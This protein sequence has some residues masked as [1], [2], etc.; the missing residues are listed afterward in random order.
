MHTQTVASGTPSAEFPPWLKP[1]VTPLPSTTNK[2]CQ[3]WVMSVCVLPRDSVR[4]Y[5]KLVFIQLAFVI[6]ADHCKEVWW[7][8]LIAIAD[9]APSI[10]FRRSHKARICLI[11]ALLYLRRVLYRMCLRGRM[12]YDETV[13][14]QLTCCF[15]INTKSTCN[16][17]FCSNRCLNFNWEQAWGTRRWQAWCFFGNLT[18]GFVLL[19]AVNALYLD[20]SAATVLLPHFRCEP[21]TCATHESIASKKMKNYW[22]NNIETINCSE[23]Q[24]ERNRAAA[25]LFCL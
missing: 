7:P 20:D 11:P 22:Q 12:S 15:I 10:A 4:E 13:A 3:V 23:R 8:W 5:R 17:I 1:L 19:A 6:P 14:E 21:S 9:D 16:G 24:S 25:N 18:V 2:V